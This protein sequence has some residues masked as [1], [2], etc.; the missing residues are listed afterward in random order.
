MALNVNRAETLF[1]SLREEERGRALPNPAAIIEAV[2][3][4][5]NAQA[6]GI[7]R[8]NEPRCGPDCARCQAVLTGEPYFCKHCGYRGIPFVVGCLGVAEGLR[9][10]PCPGDG[11]WMCPSQFCVHAAASCPVC[12]E[13]PESEATEDFD[14]MVM[15][16]AI[17]EKINEWPEPL[18]P[19]SY[20]P[21]NRVDVAIYAAEDAMQLLRVAEAKVYEAV[22]NL[23]A[24]AEGSRPA[25]QPQHEP[26]AC[27]AGRDASS[28]ERT[29]GSDICIGCVTERRL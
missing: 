12:M 11:T 3:A 5:L 29:P 17:R 23:Q 6:P 2:R 19:E 10:T 1:K 26:I 27:P 25:S 8:L 24:V 15:I 16:R 13:A 21:N 22:T 20:D 4:I 28:C 7:A 9:E 18:R 14:P